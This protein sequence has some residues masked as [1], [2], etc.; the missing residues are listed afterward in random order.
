MKNQNDASNAIRIVADVI[1]KNRTLLLTLS[2]IVVF[3]VSYLLILPAITLEE[4]EAASQGGI[5]VPATEEQVTEGQADETEAVPSAGS[6]ELA[7]S[8]DGY[9]IDLTA[10]KKAGLPED[11][12][13]TANEI[14]SDD[15]DYQ[16]WC[17]EALKAL[18]E[19]EGGEMI[20]GLASVRFYDI[21]LLSDGNPVEPEDAVDVAIS[22]DKAIRINDADQIRI[23]HF[24]ADKK[25][26]IVPE[27]LPEDQVEI[28]ADGTTKSGKVKMKETR[29]TARSFSMYAVAEVQEFEKTII[30]ADGSTYQVKVT[31]G[32]DA[33]IPEDASLEV[34]EIAE[35]DED[36]QAYTD[37][38]ADAVGAKAGDITYTK[39]LDI[40]I[41]S[42]GEQIQPAAPVDVQIRMLDRKPEGDVRVV[43]FGESIE[44]IDD[45]SVKEDVVSFEAS[46][47]SAYAIVEGPEPVSIGYET[48]KSLDDFKALASDGLYVSHF[49]NKFYFTNQTYRPSSGR[50]GIAKTKPESASPPSDAA[51]YYFEPVSGTDNK[52]YAYCFG[53]NGEKQYVRNTGNN[54]LSFTTESNKTAFTITV[55]SDGAC[56][57][58][59]N[60]YYWNQQGNANGNGF[61]AWHENNEGS[62][63]SFWYKD[64]PEEDPYG[65]D[66]KTYGLMNW[67]G[68]VAGK[69]VMGESSAAGALDAKMLT[70]MN[71]A[72]N[73]D[74]KLFVPNDSDIAMWTFTWSGNDDRYYVS[75]TQGGSTK[76]LKLDA[77]GASLADEPSEIQF[78]PGT[79]TH[80]GEICLKSGGYT[81][82]FSGNVD[83]G[84]N[85]NASAGAEWLNFVELSDLPSDYVKTY[86]A[87]KVS[88]SDPGITNGSQIIV[89]TRSWNEDKKRYDLYAINSDGTLI[90]VYESGDSIQW[91]EGQLNTLL[92][93]FTEHYY[94]GT[95]NPNYFYDLYNEYSEK[96][97]A[98]QVSDDGQILQDDPIGINLN[99]RRN[100]Q[101]YSSILAWDE[102]S[103]TYAGYKVENGRIVPCPKSEAMDFYFAIMEKQDTVDELHTVSTVDHTQYGV[104]MKM[105]D[106][107]SQDQMNNYLASSEGGAV[108]VTVPD[109]LSTDL[110][111]DGYPVTQ[112]Q[113]SG[114]SLGGLFNQATDKRTVNHLFI[115]STY[116]A[117][118]YF[119][120]DSS[121]N[122]ASL[123]GDNFKV[124]KELGAYD[125]GT[126]PT[127]KHGQFFPY[128]DIE[129]GNFCVL[130]P[131]NLYDVN[132]KLLP[133]S[134]PRKGERLHNLETG[135]KKVDPQFAMELD[136]SF[137]QTPSGKDAWGH[138][139]IF[140]FTGDD[141]FWLYV[142]GEL[143]IDLGGIHSALPGHVNF[144]TGEVVVNNGTPT[145]LREV[146]KANYLKR[147][148]GAPDDQV[149]A[150]LR[151]YFEDGSNIFKDY[152]THTMK[153]FFMERGA[154]AS[155]LH[156][157]F[158][159]ASVKPGTVEMGK[160]V[161]DKNKNV[162]KDPMAK[163]AY[164]IYYKKRVTDP[165]TG[166]HRE[167]EEQLTQTD[168]DINVTYKDTI[169]PVPC[170][171]VT[172]GGIPYEN[173]YILKPGEIAVIDFPDDTISYRIVECGVNTDVYE[174]V[175]VKEKMSTGDIDVTEDP[176]TSDRSNFGIDYASTKDR[177]L[178]TWQNTVDEDALRTM[179]F[180]KRLFKENGT[181]EIPASQD[182]T[183]FSFRLYMATELD[184]DL[185]LANMQSYCVKNPDGEYCKYVKGQGF[186]SL[187]TT[188]YSQLTEEQ[189]EAATFTTSMNGSIS[190][191][192]S[193]Y[194]VEVRN[195]FAGTRYRIVERP[196]E[197]PDGYSF[198]KYAYDPDVNENGK[199]PEDYK[200]GDEFVPAA[201]GVSETILSGKDPHVDVRNIKGW[202]LR[203]YKDWS[204]QDYMAERAPTYFAVYIQRNNPHGNGDGHV[205]LI[206]DT[207]RQLKFDA[208]PQTLYW[209]FKTLEKGTDFDHYIIRE[210]RLDGTEGV[211]WRVKEDG[212][213]TGITSN[214]HV[215]NIHDEAH[216][217]L[218]GKQKGETES[219]N[220]NYTVEYT[221]GQ[222]TDDSNVRVD[223]VKN[224]RPGIKLIKTRW[225]GTTPLEGATFKLTDNAGNEIGTF[226]SDANGLISEAF[227]TEGIPYTLTEIEAPQGWHGVQKPII[228]TQQNN[229]HITISGDADQDYYVVNNHGHSP[230]LTVKDRP[231][232]FQVIK[233]DGDSDS[234]LEGVTF[235]LHKQITVGETTAFDNTP[236]AGYENLVTDDQG[237][238]PK[239]DN[240]L[241]A[242]T[243]QIREKALST[244]LQNAGYEMLSY[245]IEFKVSK[246]GKITM[247]NDPKDVTL[248]ETEPEQGN[249]PIEYEM[250]I[251][252]YVE[253]DL[254]LHK[255]DENNE[256]LNGAKFSLCKYDTSWEEVEGYED[257]D[258]SES[259]VFALAKLSH[260]LYRL[261]ETVAPA[262]YVIGTKYT[263]FMV[264]E[265]RTVRLTDEVG[266]GENSNP[267]AAL[268]NTEITVTNHPGAELPSSGGPGTTWIYLLGAVLLLG[269]G[270]TLI[271]RRRIRT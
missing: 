236:M 177:P 114:G 206:L 62:K 247:V 13:L 128:N 123:D 225:N 145:N 11:T 108:K 155:N 238:V 244:E 234:P 262:G 55:G 46:G 146:F 74:N 264:E 102:D 150:Y 237:I 5:D 140:E 71:Q 103:Y 143:V 20:S 19:T 241:P 263:Y 253:C 64:S 218:S 235:S 113:N 202:G 100:G 42:G 229:G 2:A 17:D 115:E 36:Y 124:Y 217:T 243:Y 192:A 172:I 104:T 170:Q 35:G 212:T 67:N 10:D 49:T 60:G 132:G 32:A 75:T 173:A 254:T 85:V 207:V 61:A 211:D 248:T 271:A 178:V 94:E 246:T 127:R 142:D 162:I 122:F 154:G 213:V 133:D 83:T 76:Y 169:T 26:S 188:D 152:S 84:F 52:F 118:G 12:E 3:V 125:T 270:I 209:Y 160:E 50:T 219:H 161:L 224:D 87:T 168:Q 216:M 131:E 231:Y 176:K 183:P 89:Y 9:S 269:C 33:K 148:P 6:C 22:Y 205:D 220:Y 88:V 14:T 63:L 58:F 48:V 92:W 171:N 137:T 38:A 68:G 81:L 98:P 151:Q 82:T 232:T 223:T 59:A 97:I 267:D 95:T 185:E 164:Q 28:A 129:A 56:T 165:Q 8:G 65:L 18:Q 51:L 126:G 258:M 7:Y 190:K 136:A 90:P 259:S 39:F 31:A 159:L 226:T 189:K 4:D 230:T 130:N 210:V 180:T 196:D 34:S 251:K 149:N 106:L 37:E 265:D 158:N 117:T 245:Y 111:N 93:D 47:F 147:N 195:A 25:G 186:V 141:D 239:I 184:S 109:L 144:S 40:S 201:D 43:H 198:Q 57:V 255:V 44:V 29:F 214:Y 41:V 30:T 24:A 23:V 80:K 215:H 242:G 73:V 199:D 112:R 66:G 157:R 53:S 135:G 260:G 163:F 45:V 222:T 194:T 167:V 116:K 191:I 166:E 156:M 153:I 27:V 16:A 204:D 174:G 197:I 227:L 78:L 54:S 233:T 257:I 72:G 252:N 181:T 110:K 105:Y 79:G 256:N 138:D 96:Y 240:T 21:S 121:Q 261:E 175:A 139:I 249:D 182:S 221:K 101:Y 134:D 99:G 208:D 86:T 77:S 1:G 69:A 187:G 91:V 228:I 70:V 119:E 107:T 203:M 179:T 193:G 266:T 250:V 268:S 15:D 120:Y 200:H